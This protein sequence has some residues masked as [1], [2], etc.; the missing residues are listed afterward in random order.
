[1]DRMTQPNYKTSV[2]FDVFAERERQ[3]QKWGHNRDH[4]DGTGGDSFAALAR[5]QRRVCERQFASGRGTWRHIL[6]EEVAEAFAE[7]DP[8]LLRGELIQVAAVALA[9]AEAIDRRLGNER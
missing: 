8:V 5:H 9:W 2:S 6:E 7:S 3:N 1:M 4:R